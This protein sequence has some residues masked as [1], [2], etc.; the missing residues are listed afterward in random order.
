MSDAQQKSQGQPDPFITQFNDPKFAALSYNEQQDARMDLFLSGAKKNSYWGTLADDQKV[1]ALKQVKDMYPP[2]F[3]D[4]RYEQLRQDLE[5][6]DVSK[7]FRKFVYSEGVQMGSTG[8]AT[9]GIVNAARAM[10]NAVTGVASRIGQFFGA[11]PQAPQEDETTLLMRAMGGDKDGVKL[12]QYLQR[13]YEKPVNANIP[14]IGGQTATQLLGSALGFGGDLMTMKGAGNIVEGAV[15]GAT[16]TAA[17]VVSTLAKLGAR[18]AVT[19]TQGALR[20]EVA[21]A[22]NQALP[23]KAPVE[24]AVD[25]NNGIASTVKSVGTLWGMWAAQDLAFG[26]LGQGAAEGLSSVGKAFLRSTVGRGTAALPKAEMFE[27][28]SDGLYTPKAEAMQRN[29]VAGQLPAASRAQLG[30]IARDWAQSFQEVVDAVRKDPNALANDPVLALRARNQLMM[31]GGN[32]SLGISMVQDGAGT[33]RLRKALGKG[34]DDAGSILGEHLTFNEAEMVSHSE[35]SKAIDTARS[36]FTKWN[37]RFE[38]TGGSEDLRQTQSALLRQEALNDSSPHDRAIRDSLTIVEGNMNRFAPE[39]AAKLLSEGAMLT[40][41]EVGQVQGVGLKVAKLQVPLTDEQLGDIAER[42]TL[43]NSDKPTRFA[44]ASGG[45]YNGAI[46]YSRGAPES[47]YQAAFAKAEEFRKAGSEAPAE[48]LAH[49]YLRDQGYDAVNHANGDVTALYPQ[50]QIKHVSDL[51]SKSSREYVEPTPMPEAAKPTTELGPRPTAAKAPSMLTTESDQANWLMEAAYR[52]GNVALRKLPTGDYQLWMGGKPVSM[53]SIADVTDYFLTRSTTPTHLRASLEAEGM[54]L[55]VKDGQYTIAD[56]DGKTLGMGSSPSDAMESAHYRPRL[57][58]GRFGPKSVEVMHEGAKFEYS[59][60]GVR[61]TLSDVYKYTGSFMDVAEEEGKS[62]LQS[63]KDGKL[64]QGHDG[65]YTVEI[66][67]WGLREKFGSLSEARDYLGG[68]FKEY[69]NLQRLANEKGFYLDYDPSHGYVLRGASGTYTTR[70][71]DDLGKVFNRT[72]DPRWAPGGQYDAGVTMKDSADAIKL[73]SDT[74]PN[75]RNTGKVF[76]DRNALGQ[77]ASSA[78]TFVSNVLYP[79]RSSFARA[80]KVYG[81]KGL[82]SA[83]NS[84]QEGVKAMANQTFLDTAKANS[85][86]SNYNFSGHDLM[87]AAKV[88]Q[89][90]GDEQRAQVLDDFGITEGNPKRPA[91]LDAVNRYRSEFFSKVFERSGQDPD[92]MLVDY[93]P[94]VHDYKQTHGAQYQEM[95]MS[96][97][98]GMTQ[99]IQQ[100]NGGQVPKDMRFQALHERVADTDGLL[101]EQNLHAQA[102]LYAQAANRWTYMAEPLKAFAERIHQADVPQRVKDLGQHYINEVLNMGQSDAQDILKAMGKEG[103]TS[104]HGSLL[105]FLKTTAGLGA[106]GFK[107]SSS[108]HILE[109]THILGSGYIGTEAMNQGFKASAKGGSAHLEEQFAKGVFTGRSPITQGF[110]DTSMGSNVV[111]SALSKLSSVGSFFVQNGHI[112]AKSA[113]YDGASWLFD[114]HIKPWVDK[115]MVAPWEG[116]LHDIRGYLLDTGAADNV[117]AHL[118]AGDYEA[119]KHTYAQNMTDQITYQWRPEDQGL[120]LNKGMLAKMYGQLMVAPTGYLSALSRLGSSGSFLDRVQNFATYGKNLTA[121]YGADRLAGLSGGNLLPWRV[122]TLSGGP[123]F[124]DMN[125]LI[126]YQSGS[127][128]LKSAAKVLA[129]LTPGAP[130]AVQAAQIIKYLEAGKPYEAALTL[131]GFSV[132]PDLQLPKK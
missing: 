82:S 32:S 129:S 53:G 20:G 30:P 103:G 107:P 45:D 99:L 43:V 123:L 98:S 100:T 42:G 81:L 57:I 69:D 22:V 13:K 92:K 110:G 26:M 68:R 21:G 88:A 60:Q 115:G 101:K 95:E 90:L 2:S 40:Y 132:R 121:F 23:N 118:K 52:E 16:A 9:R 34:I 6:P 105:S 131:G 96:G 73:P 128:E 108:L 120:A 106:Y 55:Q 74:F 91:I 84:L 15:A 46:V 71:L 58:D 29:F 80:E 31:G 66:P 76:Q 33:W 10:S 79:A 72:P 89:A 51:V 94:K 126:Q 19:G 38:K 113:V 70:S 47:V 24:G 49:W 77:L 102:I 83:F 56:K 62:V 130:Q 86:L 85:I 37:E 122:I 109:Q 65:V 8:L 59:G 35:W 61:G 63:T 111:G 4:I 5:N 117:E 116:K 11:T 3:S 48:D 41:G 36:N 18:A 50:Q 93:A 12:A 54:S 78:R 27:K 64:S 17:P 14:L 104:A 127:K 39:G 1:A 25:F 67:E 44:T 125:Q 87:V 28:T 119:A 75:N 124:Q 7:P 97:P 114:R 112:L